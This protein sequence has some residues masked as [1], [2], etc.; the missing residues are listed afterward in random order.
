MD[1]FH[2]ISTVDVELFAAP[3][4]GHQACRL[5]PGSQNRC[6]VG[7]KSQNDQ[8]KPIGVSYFPGSAQ[9]RLVAPMDAVEDSHGDDA[10]L[11]GGHVPSLR[12]HTVIA[13]DS[14]HVMADR[15]Q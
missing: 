11:I 12:K 1:Y 10:A 6:W 3:T 5:G 9:E 4:H 13:R 2:P 15:A 8:G 14:I 7:I